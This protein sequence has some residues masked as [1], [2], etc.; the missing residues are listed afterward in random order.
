MP[1]LEKRCW[2]CTGVKAKESTDLWIWIVA[3]MGE[4]MS[5]FTS[6]LLQF[7]SAHIIRRGLVL[8]AVGV[9][10]ALVLYFLQIQ[11]KDALFPDEVLDT[12]FSSAWWI[13]LCCG[14]AAG[15]FD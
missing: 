8:F 5:V 4:I 2:S 9:F 13:P 3:K 14:T 10:L 1:R 11:R 6:L 15:Q 7:R 12:L